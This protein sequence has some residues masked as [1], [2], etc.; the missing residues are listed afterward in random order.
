MNVYVNGLLYIPNQDYELSSDCITFHCTP[1]PGA[2]IHLSDDV[3]HEFYTADGQQQK[4]ELSS[5][6]ME[7]I[8][9]TTL[10]QE[11]FKHKHNPVVQEALDRL[12]VALAL[13]QT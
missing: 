12:R 5:E 8:G 13:V 10:L 11:C 2:T 9:I 7:N 3:Y 1:A 4:F 6:V